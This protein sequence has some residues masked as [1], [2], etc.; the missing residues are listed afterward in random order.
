MK[1]TYHMY[2]NI[3][4]L[5]LKL[6]KYHDLI[7]PQLVGWISINLIGGTYKRLYNFGE[8]IAYRNKKNNRLVSLIIMLFGKNDANLKM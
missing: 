7:D 8:I 6:H 2:K 3:Y 4:Q 5:G 1:Q